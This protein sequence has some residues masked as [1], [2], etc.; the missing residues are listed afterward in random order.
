[1]KFIEGWYFGKEMPTNSNPIAKY[2]LYLVN[3]FASRDSKINHT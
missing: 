3:E 1:M 2:V